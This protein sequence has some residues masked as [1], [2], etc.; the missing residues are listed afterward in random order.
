MEDLTDNH[1]QLL[2]LF[3]ARLRQLLGSTLDSGLSSLPQR[4]LLISAEHP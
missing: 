4:T 1:R 2:S 3:A